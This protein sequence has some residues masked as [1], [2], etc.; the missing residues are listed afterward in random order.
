MTKKRWIILYLVPALFFA[1]IFFII[2][3]IYILYVSFFEWNGLNNMTWVGIQNYLE[4]LKDAN[5][6]LAFKNTILWILAAV[7][8]HVPFGLLLALL[9]NR[10]VF[11][12]K[13]FRVLFFLPNV[14]SITA[15]AFLWYFI[16]HQDM[17]L[18]N[19]GLR[20]VGLSSATRGWLTDL[21]TALPAT[22]VPFVLYVGLTTVIFLTQLAT[23]SDEMREAAIL[24][25]ATGWQM[26]R[27][28]YIPLVKPA[29]ATNLM[30]NVAFCLK[31]FEYPFVMTSGGPINSTTTLS[32]YVYKKMMNANQYGISMVG[33]VFTILLGFILMILVN[34]M[35]KDRKDA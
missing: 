33:S 12:W 26:D 9:L 22:M 6:Q 4:V 14:I 1:V 25:G 10:K 3:L 11:G 30:L 28:V 23:V 8:I 2:P 35:Q 31:N 17:G 27:Y 21:G 16:Y 7:C 5:F 32:L 24:D 34:R 19:W 18:L 29:I 20:T 15:L 13:V